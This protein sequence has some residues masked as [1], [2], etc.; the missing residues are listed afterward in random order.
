VKQKYPRLIE[1]IQSTFIDTVLIVFLMFVFTAVL[2]K[3]DQVPDWLR[4]GLF[5]GLFAVD[6]PLCMTLGCTL[7]N[8]LRRIRVRRHADPTQRINVWQAIVGYPVKIALGWV[9]FVTMH[10]DAQRRAIQDLV[11]GSVMIKL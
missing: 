10:G 7:G 9:S 11:S 4:I 2:E 6:E 1:L 3:L 8:Y 5:V